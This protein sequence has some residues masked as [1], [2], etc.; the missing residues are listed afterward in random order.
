MISFRGGAEGEG[1]GSECEPNPVGDER[2]AASPGGG[3]R[4]GL[5]EALRDWHVQPSRANLSSS[6][7]GHFEG[8][9]RHGR[10]P[11]HMGSGREHLDMLREPHGR[12]P[13][14]TDS[15]A[16]PRIRTPRLPPGEDVKIQGAHTDGRVSP[17]N[18]GRPDHG[19]QLVTTHSLGEG[20]GWKAR[21][22]GRRGGELVRMLRD[23]PVDHDRG[24]DERLTPGK[25][26]WLRWGIAPCDPHHGNVPTDP[27]RSSAPKTSCPL[28]RDLNAHT[29]CSVSSRD[30]SL[31]NFP[32]RSVGIQIHY[33]TGEGEGRMPPRWCC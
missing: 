29:A 32:D 31:P 19:I 7:D 12:I 30:P 2:E 1:G 24:R 17:M 22:P 11:T 25:I 23:G 13:K 4:D 26:W 15:T 9:S 33:A 8:R 10:R 21:R 3:W 28:S 16:T 5:N 20:T 6:E 14:A 27:A 18:R